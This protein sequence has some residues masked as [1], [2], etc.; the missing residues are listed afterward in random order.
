MHTPFQN[1]LKTER[2]ELRPFQ[3]SDRDALCACD[4]LP[5]VVR[6][7]LWEVRDRDETR[8]ALLRKKTQTTLTEDDSVL[9]LAVVLEET[10]AVIGEVMAPAGGTRL[11]VQPEL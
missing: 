4:A 9:C 11:C 5:E 6:Y 1:P 3:D 10:G 2:L 8:D 7:L